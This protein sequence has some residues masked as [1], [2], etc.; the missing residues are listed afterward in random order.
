ME[1]QSERGN[2]RV[3]ILIR[4]RARARA[5]ARSED[6]T[7]SEFDHERLDVYIAAIDFIALVDEVVEHL[8]RDK[9]EGSLL[10][11]GETLGDRVGRDHAR[12]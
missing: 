10:P 5:R 2:G 4:A 1:P 9:R 12:L 11:H 8:P 6:P 7:V 3:D